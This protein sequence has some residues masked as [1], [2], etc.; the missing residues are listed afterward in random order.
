[1]IYHKTVT[2]GDSDGRI[3]EVVEL[4]ARHAST[5]PSERLVLLPRTHHL[6]P[7]HE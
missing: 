7:N 4:S 6:A 1:M 5:C 3:R 2:Y